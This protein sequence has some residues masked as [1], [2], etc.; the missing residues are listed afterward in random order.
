M[1]LKS[2]DIKP[3]KIMGKKE[4]LLLVAIIVVGI[5]LAVCVVIAI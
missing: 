1:V 4:W 3:V 5:V 2:S